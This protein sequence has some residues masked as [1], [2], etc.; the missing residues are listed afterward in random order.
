MKSH[1]TDEDELNS[2]ILVLCCHFLANW[3]ISP[4]CVCLQMCLWA[5]ACVCV[6]MLVLVGWGG[7]T[8]C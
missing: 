7:G 6:W 3:L 5:R 4:L 2:F 1:G 8:M